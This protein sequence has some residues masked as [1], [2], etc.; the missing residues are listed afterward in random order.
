V[1]R[2]GR[3]SKYVE[4]ALFSRAGDRTKIRF[5]VDETIDL[6]VAPVAERVVS[7]VQRF[8]EDPGNWLHLALRPGQ[9]LVTDNFR[10]LHGR[11][12][13]DVREPRQMLRLWL[14]GTPS[15]GPLRCGI[16]EREGEV[17]TWG[18]RS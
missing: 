14:N 18:A 12:A 9:I 17:S 8:I 11:T 16:P 4:R 2:V 6:T 10:I 3:G 15:P 1:L 5:R 7:R 13:Y